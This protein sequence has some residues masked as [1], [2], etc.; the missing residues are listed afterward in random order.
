MPLLSTEARRA[1]LAGLSGWEETPSHD[2]IRKEF[3]F[4]DFQ[5]A[6]AFMTR[7]ALAAEKMDHH[8]EWTNVY[9]RVEIILSTHDAKGVTAKDIELAQ[10]IE[11]AAR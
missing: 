1:A 7:I 3:R 6:F 9:N 10:A 2:A 8:P 5:A 4:G 11:Q